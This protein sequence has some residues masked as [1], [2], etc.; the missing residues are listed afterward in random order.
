M[1]GAQLSD[2][3]HPTHE[4]NQAIRV[5]RHDSQILF[6]SVVDFTAT[7][8]EDHARISADRGQRCSQLMSDMYLLVRTHLKNRIEGISCFDKRP[9]TPLGLLDVLRFR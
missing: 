4:R 7:A 3:T 6:L 2:I 9:K 5:L 1:L 8:V